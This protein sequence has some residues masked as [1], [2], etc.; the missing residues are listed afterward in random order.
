MTCHDDVV[1][2]D[3]FPCAFKI[4]H[5]NELFITNLFALDDFFGALSFFFFLDML[6]M[7]VTYKI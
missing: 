6:M 1:F 3:G 5:A 4:G 7:I 2:L